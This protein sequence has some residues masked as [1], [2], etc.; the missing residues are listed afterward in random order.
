[1][2]TYIKI[3]SL[4][5]L[6]I[7][8]VE[9][10]PICVFGGSKSKAALDMI[11]RLMGDGIVFNGREVESVEGVLSESDRLLSAFSKFLMLVESCNDNRPVFICDFFER[12]DEAIDVRSVFEELNLSGRKVFVS[13]GENYPV[14]VKIYGFGKDIFRR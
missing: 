14:G 10:L 6:D 4:E 12:L 9:S 13:V 2:I 8:Y 7:E 3:T 11:H 5:S 1:M